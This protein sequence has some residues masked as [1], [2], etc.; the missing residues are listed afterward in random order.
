MPSR[1]AAPDLTTFAQALL[2]R[3]QLEPAKAAVVAEVLVEGDLLGHDTHGLALLAAYL[4]ELEAGTLRHA[5]EPMV[6]ADYPAALTWDGMLLPGPWLVRTALET[7]VARAK[8]NGTCTVVIRRS[9][10]T[11]CL[12]A[13]LRAV[14]EQ[15]FA[16][17]IACSD[18]AISIVAPAGGRRGVLSPNPIAAAW[19]TAGEPVILDVSLS[20]ATHGMTNRLAA[21]GAEFPGEWAVDAEGNPTRDGRVL[22]AQ[23]PGALLPLGGA[24]H[25]HKGYALGLWVEALTG[26]LAGHGR[27]DG[28]SGWSANVFIQVAAPELF[29]GEEAFRRQMQHVAEACRGTPSRPGVAAVRMPGEGGLR[30]RR[31]QLR[32][33]VQLHPGIMPA[34]EPWAAKLGVTLPRG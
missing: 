19:P 9:H 5:G 30:R 23:P 21:A 8:V 3:A 11:A 27:A 20:I 12:S 24:D 29:G 33:G 4:R 7:A 22:T 16:A 28:V 18:P 6:L 14:A 1:Y 31:E 15:G 26:G 17:T 10:H 2:E 32:D 34:L 25:G 13:Y